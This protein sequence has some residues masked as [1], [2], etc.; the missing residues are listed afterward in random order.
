MNSEA[1]TKIRRAALNDSTIK[2]HRSHIM[3]LEADV[4]VK[5]NNVY[6]EVH[7][8]FLR[9]FSIR[10]EEIKK[11]ILNSFGH[12]FENEEPGKFQIIKQRAMNLKDQW[13]SKSIKRFIEH[14]E[15]L[16]KDDIMAQHNDNPVALIHFFAKKWSIDS[17]DTLLYWGS[18][19]VSFTTCSGRCK[20]FLR[21][22][23]LF[24][25]S[26]KGFQTLNYP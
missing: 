5:L 15:A 10:P 4:K 21:R 23:F 9:Y 7:L 19:V 8:H 6:V 25:N 13:K 17:L 3:Q 14:V 26:F 1:L 20:N 22:K 12:D 24:H 18:N 16:L 11:M 2:R